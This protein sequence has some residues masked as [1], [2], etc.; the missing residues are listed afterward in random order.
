MSWTDEDRARHD[1]AEA[2]AASRAEQEAYERQ[3][4]DEHRH[5]QYRDLLLEA[6]HV[7]GPAEALRLIGQMVVPKPP[8]PPTDAEPF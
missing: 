6:V 8:D 5:E 4:E 7:L 1:A 2:A 3:L